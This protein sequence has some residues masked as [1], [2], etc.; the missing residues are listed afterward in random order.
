VVVKVHVDV[1][2]IVAVSVAVN[3]AV[4][5]A[6][7]VPV[8]ISVGVFVKVEGSVDGPEGETCFLQAPATK[9]TD[10]MQDKSKML[11]FIY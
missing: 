5:V 3:V 11:F 2:R 4:P 10:I 6:V 1:S 9:I 8:D 7:L